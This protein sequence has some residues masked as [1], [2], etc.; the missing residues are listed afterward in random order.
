MFK[1][2]QET[3]NQNSTKLQFLAEYVEYNSKKDETIRALRW[4]KFQAP[5]NPAQD[6]DFL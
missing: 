1:P 3:K 5:H 6:Q 4:G 2:E